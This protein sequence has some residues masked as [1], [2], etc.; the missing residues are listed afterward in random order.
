[1]FS[2]RTLEYAGYK[3]THVMNVTD[4]GHLTD[5][6][7]EGEDKMIK[8]AREQ[9]MTV[10]EIAEF[11][12]KA[13]FRDTERLNIHVPHQV[14]LATKH[15]QEMIDMVKTLEEKGYTYTSGGNVYFDTSKFPEYGK[16]GPDWISR[17]FSMAPETDV[18][19]NKKNA[20]DFV[21]WFTNSKFENQAMTWESPWGVGLTR[22]GILNAVP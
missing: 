12:T 1:M 8:S 7:D 14:C 6:G 22:G 18:D 21:L 3:V 2:G 16:N 13:F 5:D 4:V 17:N 10:W 19:E 15:I 20:Q 11:F 9:G